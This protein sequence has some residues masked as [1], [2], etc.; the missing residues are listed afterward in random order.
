[1]NGSPVMIIRLILLPG[2]FI[3]IKSNSMKQFATLLILS[4]IAIS[5]PAK[6]QSQQ[7]PAAKALYDTLF[8]LD[9]ALFSIAYTCQPDKVAAFFTED[10]EFYHDKGGVTR[11]LKTFLE[12][13]ERNFCG[14]DKP[15]LRRE[16]VPGSL[17]VYPMDNYG[18]IQMGEH[19]FYISQNGQPEKLTGI[20]KFT[21]LWQFRDGK[22]R[23]TRVLSYDHQAA[24]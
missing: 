9:S 20:A 19:R 1:M 24:E 15:K 17:Q 4:V 22:W 10:L 16:L 7:D 23:I 6:A 2:F 18:A 3:D 12:N 14:N 5:Q 13:L 11:S 21:H 8:R